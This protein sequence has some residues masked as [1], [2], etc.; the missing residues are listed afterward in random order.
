MRDPHIVLDLGHVLVCGGFFREIPG[1]HELG[2]EDRFGCFDDTVEG[3]RHPGNGRVFD[4]ALDIPHR[5]TRIPLIPSA[6]KILGC[7]PELHD[8]VAGQVLRADLAPLFA[9]KADQRV[10]IGAHDDAGVRTTDEPAAVSVTDV[11]AHCGLLRNPVFVRR[12]NTFGH[13]I[14]TVSTPIWTLYQ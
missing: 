11:L 8:E 13:R 4:Q 3:R 10:F 1:Q 9:P 12:T 6:V 2:F 7:F 14:D 5:S